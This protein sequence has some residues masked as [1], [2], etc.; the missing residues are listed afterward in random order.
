MIRQAAFSLTLVLALAACQ[1]D[2]NPSLDQTGGQPQLPAQNDALIPAMTI[3]TP[4]EW[5]G[6]LPTVPDGFTIAPIAKDL[7][8]PRQMLVLPNGDI[9]VAEGAG[10]HA[11]ALRPKDVIAGYIKGKG[12]TSVKGGDRVSLLRDAAAH[13]QTSKSVRAKLEDKVAKASARRTKLEQ[14]LQAAQAQA[15]HQGQG[16]VDSHKGSGTGQVQPEIGTEILTWSMDHRATRNRVIS[17]NSKGWSPQMSG[18][19]RLSR[20][21]VKRR[22]SSRL[23]VK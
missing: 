8:I 1:K 9:L 16:S 13:P 7:K 3:P 23:M 22:P 17:I 14:E 6:E 21:G 2:S 19:W 20:S 12:K 15:K 11:P 18:P 5:D 10:G 4:A